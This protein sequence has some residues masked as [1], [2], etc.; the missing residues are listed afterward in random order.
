MAAPLWVR[1]GVS[2]AGGKWL[3]VEWLQVAAGVFKW[4]P[5]EPSG[6]AS[7]GC[8]GAAGGFKWLKW[9]KWLQ[10]IIIR[11]PAPSMLFK[12]TQ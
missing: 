8:G 10:T 11:C 7:S 3:Q 4:L 6:V 2:R 9:L 1:G 5:A 12:L